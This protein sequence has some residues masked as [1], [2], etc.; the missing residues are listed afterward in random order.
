MLLLL[1]HYIMLLTQ[2][3]WGNIFNS[4]FLKAGNFTSAKIVHFNP[5]ILEY[6]LLYIAM[7]VLLPTPQNPL[8]SGW[9]GLELILLLWLLPSELKTPSPPPVNTLSACYTTA[10]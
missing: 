6:H 10:H 3:N 2:V 4:S 1:P 5:L 9:V 7:G 8:G